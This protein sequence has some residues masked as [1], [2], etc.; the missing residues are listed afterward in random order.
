MTLLTSAGRWPRIWAVRTPQW[1]YVV[2]MPVPRLY[3][4]NVPGAA[5]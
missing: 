5:E 3:F 1:G 2:L 4:V